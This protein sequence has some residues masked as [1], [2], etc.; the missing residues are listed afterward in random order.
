[1]PKAFGQTLKRLRKRMG[2]KVEVLAPRVGIAAGTLHKYE[3]GRPVPPSAVT[4]LRKELCTS[5]DDEKNFD[6]AL[7]RD[8]GT[9]RSPL[10]LP[11]DSD[12]ARLRILPV[13]YPPF[14]G[15]EHRFL[16]SFVKKMLEL[17]VI[18]YE[19]ADVVRA[20]S[21][22]EI[23]DMNQRIEW[24]SQDDADVLFNLASLQRLKKIRFLLTP[25]RVSLN[26]VML[27]SYMEPGES[28]RML[29]RAK[30]L[31]AGVS[32]EHGHEFRLLAIKNEVGWVHLIQQLKV[33]A[34]EIVT[35]STLSAFDLADSLRKCGKD[36]LPV[37]VC[38]EITAMAVLK[39]LDNEGML[40]FQPSSDEAVI[41]SLRRRS[42]PAHPLG[43]GFRRDD[44]ELYSY[45]SEALRLFLA[46]ETE[47]IAVMYE[48]LY[49]ELVKHVQDCLRHDNG[50]YLGGARRISMDSLDPVDRDNLLHQNAR[51]YARRCLQIG[52]RSIPSSPVY[53][54][55]WIRVLR[56][57]RERVQTFD[58]KDRKAIKSSVIFSF[59]AVMGLDPGQR[60]KSL[61][62]RLFRLAIEKQWLALKYVLE[63]ELDADLPLQDKRFRE[64]LADKDL[65]YFVSQVQKLL[66]VSGHTENVVA[67]VQVGPQ[68]RE[69]YGRLRERYKLETNASDGRLDHSV[70]K[71][72]P[73]PDTVAFMALNLGEPVG[74]IETVTEP[75]PLEQA[76][77]TRSGL[78]VVDLYVV[79]HMW[80][81]GISHRMIREVVDHADRQSLNSVWLH[82]RSLENRV[83]E[84]FLRCGFTVRDN[85][86]LAY[87]IDH[88]KLQSQSAEKHAAKIRQIRSQVMIHP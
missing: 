44:R 54:H 78:Q 68:E 58:A 74:F 42:L 22:P 86:T 47:T 28:E 50:L 7:L 45:I 83:K 53:S 81:S 61:D 66:E 40:V 36:R 2:I 17:A 24:L 30:T 82:N 25:I 12:K 14:S 20:Q 35:L 9:V 27:R 34:R 67:V 31:L 5:S 32:Q 70:D 6:A 8:S 75:R 4:K 71:P 21:K 33:P 52:R 85:Q 60:D 10:T 57:A 87:D 73:A 88:L 77:S 15:D 29:S 11:L 69:T 76:T 19:V 63:R 79:Q 48:E 26:A 62:Y 18:R 37:L 38:D 41:S 43:M 13:S 23:F 39:N 55:G 56:R 59:K 80:G 46:Y 49:R 51:A 84:K 1:M 72:T 3:E 16:D 64:D 65:E